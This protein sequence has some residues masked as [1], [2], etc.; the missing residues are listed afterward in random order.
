VDAQEAVRQHSTLQEFPEFAFHEGRD[1]AVAL[2]LTGQENLQMAGD[3]FIERIVLWI[4]RPVGDVDSHEGAVGCKTV[5]NSRPN[6]VSNM[7][8]RRLSKSA[9]RATMLSRLSRVCR[10]VSLWREGVR[11]MPS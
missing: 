4:A 1:V 3:Q 2:T 11:K 10:L 5:R 9:L 8:E 7:R 6:T